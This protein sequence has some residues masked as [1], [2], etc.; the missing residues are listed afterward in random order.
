MF[1][2]AIYYASPSS[3]DAYSNRQLT[4]NLILTFALIFF[5][6]PTCFHT[7]QDS[8]I[9][10][11]SVSPQHEKRNHP[12]FVNISPTLVIIDTSM[13]RSSR[14]GTRDA[15]IPIL[16]FFMSIPILGSSYLYIFI[17]YIYF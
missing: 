17:F 4:L 2:V 6:L 13:E 8:E 3:R 12:S 16:I 1:N 11:L 15:P 5:C 7:Y 14:V 9:V 10:S